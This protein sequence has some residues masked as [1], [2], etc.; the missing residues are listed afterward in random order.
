M[1]LR[2]LFALLL[3]CAACNGL[4]SAAPADGPGDGGADD[5]SGGEPAEGGAGDAT[6][7]G[8][9]DA[10]ADGAPADGGAADGADTGPACDGP[11]PAEDLATG[12]P[13]AT[14][15]TLDGQNVYF[16]SEGGNTPIQQCP[17]TGCGGAPIL[18][19]T[20]YA[21][22]IG[23][24]GGFVH[25][26]DFSNGKVW[27]CAIGGCGGNPTAIALNQTSIRGVATD[28]VKI[29]WSANNNLLGCDPAACTPQVVRA[30]TGAVLDMDVHQA[31]VLYVD[32]ASSNVYACA[33]PTCTTPLLLGAG[34][35][36]VSA[37]GGKAFW[38]TG[39]TNLIVACSIA[40]CGGSPQTIGTSFA[41]THPASDGS[42]VYFRD[43]LSFKIYRCPATGCAAGA[44]IFASDQHGQ[45]GGNL[46]IDGTHVYWTTASA[47]RRKLK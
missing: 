41:P 20:G 32:S 8:A 22:G 25:W 13:Q 9:G 26:G 17:K 3:A 42:F 23:V 33:T 6:A 47:V 21:F 28:G 7:D 5:A 1:R 40:G 31:T 35:H 38:G 29:Y 14:A 36:D 46:A 16:A 2:G 44:E 39:A 34:T 45:P 27:R 10:T 12:L 15:I 4:K 24:V 37:F 30:G 19:G 43:D 11:C 18:L